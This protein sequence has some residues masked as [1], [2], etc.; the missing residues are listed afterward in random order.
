MTGSRLRNPKQS[1]NIDKK[2]MYNN[3]DR[4][5][6]CVPV[7]NISHT[8]AMLMKAK[9]TLRVAPTGIRRATAVA[10]PK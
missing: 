3:I 1:Q 5:P 8:A 2:I 9:T 6:D 4:A 10:I 7:K